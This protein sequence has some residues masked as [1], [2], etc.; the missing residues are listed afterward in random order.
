MILSLPQLVFK[1]GDP[2]VI[3]ETLPAHF[4]TPVL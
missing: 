1:A 4:C 2:D 3:M